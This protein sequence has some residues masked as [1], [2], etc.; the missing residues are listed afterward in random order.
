MFSVTVRCQIHECSHKQ[1]QVARWGKLVWLY[2][3]V[4]V[5]AL[6]DRNA[7]RTREVVA[8][9]RRGAVKDRPP[10]F[11][12]GGRPASSGSGG[13][14]GL[15]GWLT[16]VGRWGLVVVLVAGRRVF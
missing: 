11:V 14:V 8:G 2:L 4:C 16:G 12:Q 13:T 1:L 9:V 15:V 5:C 10:V 6:P 3:R 7:Q